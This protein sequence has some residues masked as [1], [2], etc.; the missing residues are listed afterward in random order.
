MPDSR[1]PNPRES[2]AA[3][4]QQLTTMRIIVFA[5][6]MGLLT[7]G[8]VVNAFIGPADP[9]ADEGSKMLAWFGLLLGLVALVVH[10]FVG[11]MVAGAAARNLPDDE[12][13][14]KRQLMLGH[15]S[16]LIVSV[17]ILEGAAFCCLLFYGFI[18][19][20]PMLMAMAGLLFFAILIKFPFPD[21][22]RAAIDDRY[23]N[24]GM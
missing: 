12:H 20:E 3:F 15:Q 11:S 6:S 18:V 2:E 17:A 4:Q 9:P 23:R 16:G 7:F 14:A 21:G 24:R 19:G 13:A 1:E 8:F 5:L 10:R 22:V